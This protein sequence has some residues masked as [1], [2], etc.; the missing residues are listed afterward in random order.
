M[1]NIFADLGWLML[2]AGT[3]TASSKNYDG[4]FIFGG[5]RPF[6]TSQWSENHPATAQYLTDPLYLTLSQPSQ[7]PAHNHSNYHTDTSITETIATYTGTG[8]DTQYS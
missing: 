3:D 1:D 6:D 5:Y 2:N 7:A 4:L 8:S